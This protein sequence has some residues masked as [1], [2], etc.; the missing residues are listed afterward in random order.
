[1]GHRFRAFRNYTAAVTRL[2]PLPSVTGGI[3]LLVI[4]KP[5]RPLLGIEQALATLEA[6]SARTGTFPEIRTTIALWH[7]YP[8]LEQLQI[9]GQTHVWLSGIGTNLM[10]ALFLPVNAV[11]AV[12]AQPCGNYHEADLLWQNFGHVH[13]HRIPWEA[14]RGVYARGLS[15][16]LKYAIANCVSWNSVDRTE[17]SISDFRKKVQNMRTIHAIANDAI[18]N[19]DSPF[20][21]LHTF[22]NTTYAEARDSLSRAFRAFELTVAEVWRT[23]GSW[24]NVEE[25]ADELMRLCRIARRLHA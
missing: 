18:A 20:E 10:P 23:V 12:L 21:D 6:Q 13:L 8:F 22:A 24:V 15:R 2:K 14:Q 25:M 3:N 1:M 9:I 4:L 11:V 17:K 19:Y 7:W 16:E 5:Q